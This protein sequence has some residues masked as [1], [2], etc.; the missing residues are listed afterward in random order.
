M[1]IGFRVA[2]HR[3][4][5]EEQHLL[6][7]PLY[8]TD[9]EP[10]DER[11]VVPVAALFG[12]NAAGKSNVL[13]GLRFMRQMVLNSHRDAEPDG[14][15]RREPFALDPDCL[16]EP[17][18]YV[19]QLLLDGVRFDYGFSIDST[20]V[21]DEWMYSYPHGRK[22]RI[23]QRSVE[24]TVPGDS[25]DKGAM[26]LVASITEPNVLFLSLAARSRQEAVQPVYDWFRSAV[27]VR[28]GGS[29]QA[30]VRRSSLRLL[31]DPETSAVV[32]EL[33]AAADLGIERVGVDRSEV[34]PAEVV[35]HEVLL[36]ELRRQQVEE[37]GA[38]GQVF[39]RQ[40]ELDS[41][42]ERYI[43]VAQEPT[44]KSESIRLLAELNAAQAAVGEALEFEVQ[45]RGRSHVL[46]AELAALERPQVRPEAWFEQRGRHGT[47]RLGLA[48]QSDGTRL[49]L[50][51]AGPAL[52][53]LRRGGVLVVDEVDSSLH[54]RL[55][56]RLIRL[57]QDVRSN[58][59]GAQ[60]LLSTHDASLL[61]RSDGEDVLKRD[62]VW[63]VEKDAYG[64][65]TLFPLSDFKPRTVENRERR[66]LGGS[67]GAV[68]FLSDERF[69]EALAKRGEVD[70]AEPT[71]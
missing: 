41:L 20:Q 43:S 59:L 7:T 27:E 57:F 12:S 39:F 15:I 71:Q 19:V 50:D 4:L 10:E 69:I 24:E 26:D 36:S 30:G 28:L 9:R 62:Q 54:P 68:P 66:Y 48:A 32:N 40:G 8:E 37:N 21:L 67:Y 47:A 13:D 55:T 16:A 25:T 6:L 45:A 11:P 34:D 31:E 63:F 17:S 33:L 61:G 49:L 14:G 53:A 65:S 23:F 70:G 60:L 46:R 35:R 52:T 44:E 56:A 58:P 1:L 5:R 3:S 2:N 38:R 29:G 22:R 51:L 18:W 42:R 64:E